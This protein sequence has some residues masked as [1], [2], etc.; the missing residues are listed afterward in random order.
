MQPSHPQS[1]SYDAAALVQHYP[2]GKA[3]C[4]GVFNLISPTDTVAWFNVN[5]E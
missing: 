1:L 3:H 2:R 5:G 4:A